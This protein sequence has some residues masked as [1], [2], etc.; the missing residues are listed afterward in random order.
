M[1][2]GVGFSDTVGAPSPARDV[3]YVVT[4]AD[5]VLRCPRSPSRPVNASRGRAR[6]EEWPST[7][8]RPR[9]PALAVSR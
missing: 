4:S 5:R 1:R 8:R 9:S 6:D 3:I 7:H 2:V